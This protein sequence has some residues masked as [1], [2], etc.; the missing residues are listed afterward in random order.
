MRQ[1][2]Q[3]NGGILLSPVLGV[4]SANTADGGVSQVEWDTSSHPAVPIQRC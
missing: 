4:G 1:L 2:T 3:K